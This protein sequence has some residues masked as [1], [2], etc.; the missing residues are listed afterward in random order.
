[1]LELKKMTQSK[2]NQYVKTEGV[3]HAALYAAMLCTPLATV[4]LWTN[5]IQLNL[6]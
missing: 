2:F 6:I 5:Q 1:M 3:Q 4:Q